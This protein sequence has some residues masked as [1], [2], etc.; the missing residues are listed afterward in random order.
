LDAQRR[1]EAKQAA[2]D[3]RREKAEA[4]AE[5]ALRRRDAR[6][7]EEEARRRLSADAWASSK[8]EQEQDYIPRSEHYNLRYRREARQDGK[9]VLSVS[10]PLHAVSGKPAHRLRFDAILTEPR[11]DPAVSRDYYSRSADGT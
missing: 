10:E 7:A 6:D 9:P 8:W 2:A 3:A 5:A 4:A 11:R 1:K